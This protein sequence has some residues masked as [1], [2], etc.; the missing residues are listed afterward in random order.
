MANEETLF[1]VISK[2][3]LNILADITLGKNVKK[4]LP[5]IEECIQTLKRKIDNE[6][7]T[8]NDEGALINLAYSCYVLR[9]DAQAFL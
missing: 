7:L 3:Y 9:D 4:H 8:A 1:D 5:V 6:L 2:A